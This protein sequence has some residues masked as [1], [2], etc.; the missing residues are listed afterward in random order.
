MITETVFPKRR[1]DSSCGQAIFN[2][3]RNNIVCFYSRRCFITK[4]MVSTST[5]CGLKKQLQSLPICVLLQC[6]SSC[7]CSNFLK[8]HLNALCFVQD[9]YNPIFCEFISEISFC[10]LNQ[11]FYFFLL[12]YLPERRL[13]VSY[14]HELG[15]HYFYR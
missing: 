8:G 1:K 2:Q 7:Q 10:P 6:R 13:N 4:I 14:F 3:A 11:Q 12:C 5:D 15:G 9:F